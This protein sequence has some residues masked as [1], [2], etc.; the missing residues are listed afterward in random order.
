MAGRH[1]HLLCD[2]R[3]VECYGADLGLAWAY[4]STD[5]LAGAVDESRCQ[6]AV[7]ESEGLPG[8]S[9][10]QR[11]AVVLAGSDH[12]SVGRRGFYRIAH[13]AVW[14]LP[15]GAGIERAG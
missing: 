2:A 9:G 6:V 15:P 1:F 7:P 10:A 5:R 11:G 8:E 12:R 4:L 14:G 3:S 13:L